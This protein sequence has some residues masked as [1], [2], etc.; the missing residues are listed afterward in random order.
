MMK[1]KKPR[2]Y[3]KKEVTKSKTNQINKLIRKNNS[4]T[5]NKFKM[6]YK[7]TTF[8]ILIVY[9]ERDMMEFALC[10]NVISARNGFTIVVYL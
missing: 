6:L 3:F 1:K 5:K 4:N 2:L 7:K 8:K 10:F 9:V